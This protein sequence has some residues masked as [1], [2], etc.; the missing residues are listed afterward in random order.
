MAHR[1]MTLL[2]QQRLADE[3]VALRQENKLLREP[4]GAKEASR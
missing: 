3:V 4:S 1:M 2:E